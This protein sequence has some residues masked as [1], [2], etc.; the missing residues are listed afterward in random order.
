LLRRYGR[1]YAM[2]LA[3]Q[4]LPIE[5]YRRPTANPTATVGTSG[6]LYRPQEEYCEWHVVRD[7][8]TNKIVRIT[9]CSEPPEYWMALF[10]LVPGDGDG[11]NFPYALFPGDKELLVNLYRTLV[12]PDVQLEDLIAPADRVDANGNQ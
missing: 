7:P 8:D 4:V 10:G 3:D 2:S 1:D 12:S 9:F 5:R 11:G 6:I